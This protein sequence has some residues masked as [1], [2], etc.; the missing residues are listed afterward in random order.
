LKEATF[1]IFIS[2]IE[3]FSSSSL[4]RARVERKIHKKKSFPLNEEYAAA[5]SST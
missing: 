1:A 4:N 3:I 2:S 5:A